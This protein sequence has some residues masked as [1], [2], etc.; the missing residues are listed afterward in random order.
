MFIKSRVLYILESVPVAA[1]LLCIR[2]LEK[3]F[4]PGHLS[5]GKAAAVTII[6]V[7]FMALLNYVA[8]FTEELGRLLG[9]LL[10]GY[11]FS[12]FSF[13]RFTL[14]KQRRKLR[15]CRTSSKKLNC[16]MVPPP[17]ENGRFP[18]KL[19][20]LGGSLLNLLL[21]ACTA[22][23]AVRFRT[24][25][26]ALCAAA[27]AAFLFFWSALMNLIPLRTENYVNHAYS[28]VMA[29]KTEESLYRCYAKLNR[30][31]AELSGMRMR[32]LPEAWLRMP[33]DYELRMTDGAEEAFQLHC[34]RIDEHRFADAL[35][36]ADRIF[37][38]NTEGPF[39]L[40]GD[41]LNNCVYLC[42]MEDKP[43][44]GYKTSAWELFRSRNGGDLAALRTEYAMALLYEN[45]P[46]R[47]R[48]IRLQ[49]E[50]TALRHPAL[51]DVETERELI[52]LAA[53]KYRKQTRKE[54]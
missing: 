5:S 20:Y 31:A 19:Y 15:L 18:Y 39:P 44:V 51:A 48:K 23:L 32:D 13:G 43:A 16:I 3:S 45:D 38:Q 14:A 46:E 11:K 6:L 24:Q 25:P 54:P 34:K 9:G 40:Q 49:F 42:L 36:I 41:L 26:I 8:A 7:L 52:E 22:L 50:R 27:E 10:T 12:S 33:R 2:Y 21:A 35:E 28:A 17:M 4:Y 37:A 1:C 47:A 29:G 30:L 53:E